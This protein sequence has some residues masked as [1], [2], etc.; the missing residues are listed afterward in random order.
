MRRFGHLLSLA[1]LLVG[2]T[3]NAPPRQPTVFAPSTTTGPA[4][5]I[6]HW[7]AGPP[8]IDV[9]DLGYEVV[10]WTAAFH[11]PRNVVVRV[12]GLH[13]NSFA[14]SCLP[15]GRYVWSVRARYRRAGVEWATRWLGTGPWAMVPEPGFDTFEVH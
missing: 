10:V 9:S 13:T 5:P 15:P 7:R 1:T 6:L 11:Q 14:T 4:G 8:A 3:G 12:E 2:C